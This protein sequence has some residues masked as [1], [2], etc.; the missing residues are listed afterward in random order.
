[1]KP[2]LAFLAIPLLSASAPAGLTTGTKMA[3]VLRAE[4]QRTAGALADFLHDS[5]PSVRRRAALAAGRIGDPSLALALSDRLN[6][7]VPE[8]RR[9]AALA[10]GL[11]GDPRSEARLEGALKDSDAIVRARAAQAIGYLG[12]PKGAA[13]VAHMVMAAVPAGASPLTVRGDDAG[14]PDDPWLELRLGLFALADLKDVPTAATVLVDGGRSRF[15]WWAATWVATTL[16]AP[17]LDPVL[18]AAATS[19][20]KWSRALAADGLGRRDDAAAF[21]AL[22]KLVQDREE[23]VVARALVALGRTGDPR[24]PQVIEPFLESG[25]SSLK[26]SA[27][28]ALFL[29]SPDPKT[30]DAVVALAGHEEP[31]IRA[32]AMR[33]LARLDPSELALVLSGS[34]RDSAWAVRA[35]VAEGL[36]GAHD[37][38]SLGL[39][40]GLLKDEDPRVVAAVIDPLRVSLGS[41]SSLALVQQLGQADLGVRAAAARGLAALGDTSHLPEL[42]AAYQRSLGDRDPEARLAIVNAMATAHNTAA[43]EALLAAVKHDPSRAI[44]VE[45][46]KAAAALGA[47]P[48]GIE[49]EEARPTLDYLVGMAPYNPEPGAPVFTPRAFLHTRRGTIEI[50]L[51][52]VEAPLAADMFVALA[53]RGFFNGVEFNRVSPGERVEGG[54]PRGDGLGGPGYRIRREAGMKPF[55][56]GAVGLLANFKDTEGSRFFIAL[57]PDPRQDAHATL[58]GTVANGLDVVESLRAHD[59][60]DRVE[61][62]D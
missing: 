52:T 17:E 25:S 14:N 44:R 40:Y 39:L 6:D 58:L 38:L 37:E 45:A 13:A 43:S 21:Q 42:S 51:N 11:I 41:A 9:V 4:D 8:V 20:D 50:H 3:L 57:S 56:R 26:L 27:L 49:P 48:P 24:A 28:D 16:K 2:L 61:I 31:A 5:S 32:G 33:L 22:T 36:A 60:I 12:D 19:A 59:T 29:L 15:D 53:R 47:S 10:L 35:A 30:R 1:M 7:P 23:T 18:Y 62:W 55:G 46:A 54:C 34:G